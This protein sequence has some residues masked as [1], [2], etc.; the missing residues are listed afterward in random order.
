MLVGDLNCHSTDWYC[1]NITPNGK[2]LSGLITNFNLNVLNSNKPTH[3]SYS[4]KSKSVIDLFIISNDLSDK[5]NYFKVFCND[6]LSDHSPICGSF[7][8][9]IEK[10][11]K[12]NKKIFKLKRLT[13]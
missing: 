2:K 8:I 1:T 5:F 7:N 3:V 12:I 10:Y 13:A 11:S 6:I 4:S 9:E